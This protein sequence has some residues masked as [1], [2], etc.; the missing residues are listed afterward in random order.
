MTRDKF[1]SVHIKTDFRKQTVIEKFFKNEVYLKLDLHSY[2]KYRD[3]WC[4]QR[5]F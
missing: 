4:S 3:T 1:Y 5:R 2:V